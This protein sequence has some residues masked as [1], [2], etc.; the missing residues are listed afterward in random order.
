[1]VTLK[2]ELSKIALDKPE[3]IPLIVRLLENPQ[4]PLALPGAISLYDHD[5]LHVLLEQKTTP[6]GEAFIV[7]FCMGNAPETL[8][9]HTT[10]LKFCAKYLYPQEYRFTKSCLLE[11]ERGFG[12]GKTFKEFR[13][14]RID[15][16]RFANNSVD[17]LQQ[18]FGISNTKLPP[19][20]SF[21]PLIGKRKRIKKLKLDRLANCLKWSSSMFALVGG[22]LLALNL[23]LSRFG[24]IFLA[25]SS[26]QLLISSLL[27]KE[28][29][30]IVY[31]GAVFFG[32]NLLGI[33][34]WVFH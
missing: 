1:M 15:F 22:G 6:E 16:S 31:S 19:L 21:K 29:T 4:S 34:R 3:D 30:M 33:Y 5:C 23:P 27:I 28:R 32:V 25:M 10:I 14:N 13:F 7:G 26:S 24:F 2:Q 17:Q 12:Y 20:H 8:Q 9:I 11:F 18:Y